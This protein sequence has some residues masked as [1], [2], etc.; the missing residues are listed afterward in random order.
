MTVKVTEYSEGYRKRHPDAPST[1]FTI[2]TK[3]TA[4]PCQLLRGDRFLLKERGRVYWVVQFS[5]MSPKHLVERVY[6]PGRRRKKE[7]EKERGKKAKRKEKTKKEEEEKE[8]EKKEKE[9]ATRRQKPK[10]RGIIGRRY[11]LGIELGTLSVEEEEEFEEE[12]ELILG[13]PL[14]ER[15]AEWCQRFPEGIKLRLELVD[16]STLRITNMCKRTGQGYYGAEI[17]YSDQLLWSKRVKIPGWPH[18]G[19]EVEISLLGS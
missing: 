12:E 5:P 13:R 19:E 10:L 14:T 9:T 6:A 4:E 8:K 7:E 11:G 1:P 2:Y 16:P 17:Y 18:V 3:P 15:M